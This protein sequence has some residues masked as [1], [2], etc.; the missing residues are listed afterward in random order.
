[1][2][3]PRDGRRYLHI[4]DSIPGTSAAFSDICRS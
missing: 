3:D 2:R 4:S 1:L